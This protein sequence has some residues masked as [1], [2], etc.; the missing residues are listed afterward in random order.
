VIAALI[1]I[2]VAIACLGA[3]FAILLVAGSERHER[4]ERAQNRKP[5]MDEAVRPDYVLRTPEE[6][7]FIMRRESRRI[8]RSNRFLARWHAQEGGSKAVAE[9]GDTLAVM[10]TYARELD[11]IDAKARSYGIQA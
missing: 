11:A 10:L 7:D 1:I 8:I 4:A 6:N 9:N 2:G 5:S 3:T